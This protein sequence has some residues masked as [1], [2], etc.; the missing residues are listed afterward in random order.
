MI[1]H[2]SVLPATFCLA[3]ALLPQAQDREDAQIIEEDYR[4]TSVEGRQHAV[5]NLLSSVAELR[6]SGQMIAAARALNR[7]GRFRIRMS[8]PK[9]AAT[10]FQ[11]ALELLEQQPDIKTQVDSLNGL[12]SSYGVNKCELAEP[13]ANQALTLSKQNNYVAGEAE[14]LRILSYCQDLRDHSLALKTAE[15]SLSLSSSIGHKRGMGDAYVAM[16][17]YQMAQHNL[18]ECARNLD[19]ALNIFRDLNDLGEQAEVLI[20]FG[21]IGYRNGDWQGALDYYT[22]AES[23]IDKS[24]EPYK[25]GQITIGLG[26][27]FLE[28]GMPEI[29]LL[30]Y[31]ESLD[32]FRIAEDQRAMSILKWSIGRANY[33]DGQY[34]SALDSLKTARSE[35]QF[36]KDVT[37]TAFCDDYLGRTYYSMNDHAVALNHFQSA[38]DGYS[39]TKNIRE[40]ERVR[41]LIGRVYQQQGKWQKARE[42]YQTALATFRRLA[43][44][45]NE[46]AT[47]YA[48]GTL[49]LQ[50]NNLDKAAEYLQ[51]SVDITE[52]MRR[53]SSRGDLTAAFSDTVY[54]RY[55][56]Y[57][58]CLMRKHLANPTQRY[59]VRAFE[60]SESARGR[61]LA[62]LL[63]G[64]Q[65]NLAPGVEPQLAEREKS[66]RQA[67]RVKENYRI[68]LLGKP[69]KQEELD[70]LNSELARLSAE[71]KEVT[72]AITARN[73]SYA[74]INRPQSWDLHRIQEQ[75]IADDETVLLEFS[76]GPNRSYVWVVT[77]NNFTSRELAPQAEINKAAQ[78]V[79][80]LLRVRPSEE[81]YGKLSVAIKTLSSMVVAPVAAE[82]NK[83]RLIIV[84][85]GAL[86]YIPF[87][88]LR[89]QP[90]RDDPLVG[91]CEIDG[92]PSASILGQ[93][94]QETS[95]RKDPSK[96]LA[97]FGAPVF[98]SNYAQEINASSNEQI[99]ALQ[100]PENQTWRP[101]LRD[102]E[103]DKD[104][105]DSSTIQPLLFTRIELSN[106]RDVA[107]PDS[108]VA[109]GFDATREKLSQIDLQEYA[110]LH[111]AT[112][113]I[114]DPKRPE[115]SGLLFT[116]VNRE[117]QPQNGFLGLQD[118]YSLHAPV[119]LVVLSACRTG[120]GKDVR[121]EGLIGLT[122]G[123]MY[124]GA[125]SVVA[126]LWKVDD[127]ATAEL[128]KRFY[129]NMLHEGMTP[130]AALRAAQNSIRQ[131]SQ[132]SSPYHW[133]A[134]TL[135]GDY[136]QS[137]KASSHTAGTKPNSSGLL[138][139]VLGTILAIGLW[140]YYHY[141]ARRSRNQN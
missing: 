69:Y 29:A 68:N 85:D 126:S 82:L 53:V 54:D 20:Y 94:R 132:W 31:Q 38:L 9:D 128:M 25:M 37:L 63:R 23:M 110:I 122:R 45:V 22:R 47:L 100:I 115:K 141:R 56:T 96:S 104:N 58:E 93:L 123:F 14:A 89:P 125:S 11:Q 112:H 59:D 70:A 10:T 34:Q 113:G 76:L 6:N 138:I 121:G 55:E 44:R 18:E 42:D 13:S 102:I 99:T 57:I 40:A 81:T 77:R 133:A 8:M 21:Y 92:G 91:Q 134:F 120:L 3:L 140:S 129:A 71:F 43:D 107:G 137:I 60:L 64:T 17:E 87:Q 26:D 124:A 46:S 49:E 83:R 108:F 52:E 75:V 79:Y 135:Q 50:E 1:R 35:A 30:K 12:A 19:A 72:D 7:V 39:S 88:I 117:G 27:S 32:Y 109:T 130:A 90:D 114:L 105:L 84:A 73:P 131:T 103:T 116:M 51:Q 2:F 98:A 97:A 33:F 41:A 66:L 61:S 95:R 28:S 80:G 24:A 127:E 106:L 86:N 74:E 48:M 136:R 65:T 16:G 36:S 5:E 139:V 4:V 111:I 119:D 101:A 67:L 62:D 15:H 118:V 78:D